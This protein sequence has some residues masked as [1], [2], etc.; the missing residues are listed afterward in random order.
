M[1]KILMKLEKNEVHIW[2]ANLAS[3]HDK[4]VE[5]IALLSM[6][7]RKRAEQFRFL[8]HKRRFIATRNILRHILSQYV[9]VP[10]QEIIFQYTKYKKPHLLHPSYSNLQF[11]LAHSHDLIVYALTLDHA[12]G[13]DIE[14]IQDHYNH[15]VVKRFFS[16]QE[17]NELTLLSAQD[18]ITGF[19]RIWS[20]KEALIKATGRGLS[21]PLS[22]FSVAA[23]DIQETIMLQD[24]IWTLLPLFIHSGYQAALASNQLI[25]HISYWHFFDQI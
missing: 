16:A 9:N 11:N 14:K 20:R 5:E 7:E 17:N 25:E 6:D 1:Q 3:T 19:Y 15:D 12:I 2:S 10:P 24:E 18:K 22:S 4:Q 8:I 21:I 23:K 13:I